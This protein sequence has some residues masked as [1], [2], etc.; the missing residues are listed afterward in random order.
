MKKFRNVKVFTDWML[1]PK[2]LQLP[3]GS[4]SWSNWRLF[5]SNFVGFCRTFVCSRFFRKWGWEQCYGLCRALCNIADIDFKC[6][7]GR[8]ARK[9][10]WVCP[11]RAKENAVRESP[12]YS[13]WS[14]KS[15]S[16]CRTTRP[17]RHYSRTPSLF[18][19]LCSSMSETKSLPT[20][21]FCL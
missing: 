7:R 17:W 1:S 5:G 16:P 13:Q 6:Y 10:C 2:N 15:Q 20:A 8:M 18:R 21:E 14:S 9:Q 12:L 3:F 11:Q 19:V 4:S